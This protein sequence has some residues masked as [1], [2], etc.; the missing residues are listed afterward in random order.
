MSDWSAKN[1]TE[2]PPDK[3]ISEKEMMKYIKYNN[4]PAIELENY[5][6]HTQAV[7]RCVKLS[8]DAP[9]AMGLSAH[10]SV[11]VTACQTLKQKLNIT[12]KWKS[13]L[14][15]LILLIADILNKRFDK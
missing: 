8:S 6:C 4:T 12:F 15:A 7:E 9:G 13:I 10:E 1:I 3:R 2:L 14:L 11:R 5:P